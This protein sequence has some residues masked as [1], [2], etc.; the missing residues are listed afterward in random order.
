M[1]RIS[2]FGG[3]E[4][5]VPM[6][7]TPLAS[8][9]ALMADGHSSQDVRAARF[10]YTNNEHAVSGQAMLLKG[11]G[12]HTNTASRLHAHLR[13]P[14]GLTKD[15]TCRSSWQWRW[16]AEPSFQSHTKHGKSESEHNPKQG[17]QRNINKRLTL[18]AISTQ[19]QPR[20]QN[21]DNY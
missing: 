13:R 11:H 2:T 17:G 3:S 21:P 15:R 5:H 6:S 20:I 4:R 10:L 16:T 8:H 19:G 12:I 1:T 9:G 14:L 7:S 18:T